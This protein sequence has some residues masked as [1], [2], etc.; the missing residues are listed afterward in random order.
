MTQ[1]GHGPNDNPED[2]ESPGAS[3]SGDASEAASA[4]GHP[5]EPE[6]WGPPGEPDPWG[7]PPSGSNSWAPPVQ[8]QSH[9]DPW[10]RPQ[11]GE[12]QNTGPAQEGQPGQSAVGEPPSAPRAPYGQPTYGEP[13]SA[14][15]PPYGQQ[16]YGQPPYGQQPYGQAPY[17]QAPYGQQPYAAGGGFP[18]APGYSPYGQLTSPSGAATPAG[19]GARLGA[20]VLDL[21]IVGIPLG[22]VF[23]VLTAILIGPSKTVCDNSSG[24][25]A[26]TTTGGNSGLS[27]IFTLIEIAVVLGYFGYFDGVKQQTLGKRVLK[28][29]VADA[30]T[31]GPIGIGRAILRQ[32]VLG[33]TGAICLIGY[34]SPFFDST[35]RYQG[36]HDKAGSDFVVMAG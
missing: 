7:Q 23:G 10:A 15:Q 17:G 36:W 31:G 18:P 3:N 30:T 32:I 12:A 19:M 25:F 9:P 2:H 24:S 6:P 21:L 33:I 29:K 8:P 26:C 27:G 28:I 22:I 35:K 13:P 16:P 14:P 34:F 4:P 1:W 20:Y 11:Q 5:V